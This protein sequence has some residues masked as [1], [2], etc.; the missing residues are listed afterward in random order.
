MFA[1]GMAHIGRGLALFL[2]A[3]RIVAGLEGWHG[4]LR[5]QQT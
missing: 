3:L 2:D 1:D 5:L 4:L